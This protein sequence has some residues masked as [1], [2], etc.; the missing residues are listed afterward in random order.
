MKRFQCG[1]NQVFFEN[2]HCL[3]CERELGFVPEL[4]EMC[5]LL[6]TGPGIYH[7]GDQLLE[8]REFRKC[9]NY[10]Q[11]KVCNWMVP[12]EDANSFCMAC[13][14]NQMI[15]DLSLPENRDYWREIEQAKRRL[16]FTLLSLELPL[17]GRDED[18][19]YGLAFAFLADSSRENE[20]EFTDKATGGNPIMT[21]H[22]H[23][24]VTI[25]IAE[26]DPSYR[27][28]IRLQ[29][30]ESYRTLLGHFRHEIGHYYWYRLIFNR[31]WHS[32]FVHL[33][34]NENVNYQSSLQHYYNAGPP[35]GWQEYYISAYASAHPWEDWAECWAHYLHIMD[36]L[37]TAQSSNLLSR[38]GMLSN[39]ARRRGHSLLAAMLSL[40][41]QDILGVWIDLSVA[42]N[43][44]NR[45]IGLGDFY[46]FVIS[47]G[48][49]K[50]LDFIHKLVGRQRLSV[51]SGNSAAP[52]PVESR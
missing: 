42:M 16:L 43:N 49:M 13:R 1:S 50:K 30:N 35:S 24:L 8:G 36:T 12:I 14:L 46:P 38:D 28:Q 39:L 31:Y 20:S 22:N 33:F 48:V 2:T 27:E 5:P 17:I 47:S 25:N 44:I 4:L 15:P 18:P 51:S 37:E 9:V 26:A 23:G 34:G 52:F 7:L 3:E 29:M 40:P 19:E 11:Q 10:S 45:S 21:G 6:P 41:L 32:D